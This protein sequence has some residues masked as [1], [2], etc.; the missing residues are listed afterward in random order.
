MAT[1]YRSKKIS[2]DA[3]YS[4][5]ITI[6]TAFSN[7]IDTSFYCLSSNPTTIVACDICDGVVSDELVL[8]KDEYAASTAFTYD[9]WGYIGMD[10]MP[11][12]IVRINTTDMTRV[13]ALTLGDGENQIVSS[14]H[15]N[16]GFGYF[17][18]YTTPIRLIK[19]NL[20]TMKRVGTLVFNK[21]ENLVTSSFTDG[22]GVGYFATSIMFDKSMVSTTY[23]PQTAK[24]V[25]VNLE[26]MTHMGSS[27]IMIPS[28]NSA[29]KPTKTHFNRIY[30]MQS[31]FTDYKGYGYFGAWMG[32]L[33]DTKF[34]DNHYILKIRLD[35]LSII[36]NIKMEKG[37]GG[38]TT[39]FMDGEYGYFCTWK[40]SIIKVLLSDLIK[41]EKLKLHGSEKYLHSA[42]VDLYS[43][44]CYVACGYDAEILQIGYA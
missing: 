42:V 6:N 16:D 17:S 1:M 4:N 37:E 31:G 3:T 35:D 28:L 44:I 12:K 26:T 21:G 22:L 15:T 7:H 18:T 41:S 24:I 36:S 32:S 30:S 23:P 39:S 10:T 20:K 19:V 5:S 2:V 27:N 38:I 43:K 40:N 13:D 25:K 14:F 9:K 11:A 8:N 33:R 29:D 34:R